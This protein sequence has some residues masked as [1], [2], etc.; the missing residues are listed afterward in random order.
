[1]DKAIKWAEALILTIVSIFAPIQQLLITTAVLISIDLI[2]GVVAAK[3]R[4]EPVTS[5]GLRRT[6]SKLF[7]YELAL[8]LAYI[9]EK[10]LSDALPFVKM[11]TTMV[12][13]VE[14]KSILE[15]LNYISGQ[16]LLKSLI[17][18]LGSANQNK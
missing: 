6:I 7:I 14:L 16:D 1:M 15:N 5:A 12:S 18:K 10:Y 4:K 13:V 9:T 17:D 11:V 2:S 8:M 3:K